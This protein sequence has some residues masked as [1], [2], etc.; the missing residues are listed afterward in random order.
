[1]V[2]VR[3]A[4]LYIYFNCIYLPNLEVCTYKFR[5]VCNHG[6]Y[7]S[8]LLLRFLRPYT[9]QSWYPIVPIPSKQRDSILLYRTHIKFA[10]DQ[11]AVTMRVR[12]NIIY[13]KYVRM[14]SLLK[15]R[16]S[17]SRQTMSSDEQTDICTSVMQGSLIIYIVHFI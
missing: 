8:F 11:C 1:M 10:L 17:S 12:F 6:R 5:V 7:I 14:F 13:L 15:Y 16:T 4:L 9:W 3:R 2:I